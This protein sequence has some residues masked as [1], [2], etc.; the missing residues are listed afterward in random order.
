M[1]T[2][3]GFAATIQRELLALVFVMAGTLPAAAHGAP[4]A[5]VTDLQGKALIVGEGRSREVTILA[6]LES[7]TQVQLDA[8]AS[9]VTL[10]LDAGDDYVF[11][12]PALIVFR[13]TQPEIV[14]GTKPE[15][16]SS[17]FGRGGKDI[18]IMPVR[19]AQGAIVMR[20][21]QTGARI[22]LL[23]L[24]ST[25]TLES[26]PEFRWQEPQAGVK[27]QFEINDETGRTLHEAQLDTTSFRLPSSVQLKDDVPYTWAVSARLGDGR[28]Y[29]SAGGF[30][31]APA[32][33]RARAEA[34][35]PAAAAPLS[36]RIA[37][38]AWLEQM[39]LKDEARKYWQAASS[40]RPADTR[41]KALA[42]Q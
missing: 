19:L 23:S 1:K 6:E 16:R 31:V 26:R 17:P 42:E 3:S 11:K 29:T 41:L 4:V 24:R 7:G 20:N 25:R 8:G 5:M 39:D 13:P 35:R 2:Q 27:F 15:R 34:L 14:K 12:G 18:R 33:L 28:K 32:E 38:A 37:Y 22:R 21:V 9:L 30:S 36:A 10:Y 40:E